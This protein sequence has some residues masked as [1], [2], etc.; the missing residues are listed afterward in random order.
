MPDIRG[1]HVETGGTYV[2]LD[3]VVASIREY[4]QSLTD[5]SAGA[6]I[7]ELASWLGAS[8]M[9]AAV[10]GITTVPHST[11]ELQEAQDLSVYRVELYPDPPEDPK[12]KWY[13]RSVDEE[14][15]I[16]HTTNGAYDYEHVYNTA[17]E[18]WPGKQIYQLKRWADDSVF[19]EKMEK[20]TNQTAAPLRDRVSP[21]RMFA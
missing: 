16:L 17:A 21:K 9:P 4:A 12:P 6:A 8:S 14:G 5:P 7:H 11:E 20:N 2:M 3:D 15:N 1:I 18:R 19:L 10:A 13:A